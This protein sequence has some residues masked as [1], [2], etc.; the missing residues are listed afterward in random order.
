MVI[1]CEGPSYRVHAS[2][3]WPYL[4][5]HC[6]CANVALGV[7]VFGIDLE[8]IV[9][10]HGDR[11][12]LFHRRRS[13]D[14]VQFGTLNGKNGNWG[15]FRIFFFQC[16]NKCSSEH[17]SGLVVVATVGGNGVVVVPAMVVVVF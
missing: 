1:L 7:T 16:C 10:R 13:S 17:P 3:V 14:I 12:E 11:N 9:Q 5:R 15:V 8:K 4:L 6:K 2:G